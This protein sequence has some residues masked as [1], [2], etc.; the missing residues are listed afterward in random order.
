MERRF[1]SQINTYE[2]SKQI[3]KVY[4]VDWN[5]LLN[6]ISNAATESFLAQTYIFQAALVILFPSA[7]EV[8]NGCGS[9]CNARNEYHF[10]FE[11]G[12][13]GVGSEARSSQFS[14]YPW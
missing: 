10:N 7:P 8:L 13:T 14:S 12:F 11:T 3:M 9:H 5:F 2:D 1:W 4:T 6:A